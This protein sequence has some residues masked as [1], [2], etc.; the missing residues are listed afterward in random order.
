LHADLVRRSVIDAKRSGPP[1]NINSQGFPG[2]R[3]LKDPL[4]QVTCKEERV[5]TIPSE[6]GKEPQV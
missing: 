6:C 3:L 2:K 1:A 4:A 5:G